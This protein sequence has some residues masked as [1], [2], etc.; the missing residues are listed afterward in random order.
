MVEAQ[1]MFVTPPFLCKFS[2]QEFKENSVPWY[3]WD[4]CGNNIPPLL[5]QFC[6][7]LEIGYSDRDGGAH[8]IAYLSPWISR[9]SLVMLRLVTNSAHWNMSRNNVCSCGLRRW[10]THMF[11]VV[12]LQN[13]RASLN[14]SDLMEYPTYLRS[15][16]RHIAYV[17]FLYSLVLLDEC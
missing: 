3:D 13:G 14:L 15:F 5:D 12:Q 17:D 1:E 6:R 2:K 9:P 8:Q 11:L 7:V 4:N 16:F 10:W